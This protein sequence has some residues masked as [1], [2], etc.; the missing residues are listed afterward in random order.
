MYFKLF[1]GHETVRRVETCVSSCFTGWQGYK[2][3]EECSLFFRQMEA[4]TATTAATGATES[5][6]MQSVRRK[7]KARRSKPQLLQDLARRSNMTV[8]RLKD[9][10]AELADVSSF[11]SE[12]SDI[13]PSNTALEL[14]LVDSDGTAA[15]K[16]EFALEEII[17]TSLNE[18][19]KETE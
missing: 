7:A 9:F 16:L 3:S 12:A 11:I 18:G 1:H 10:L 15:D 19:T 17:D 5:K 8:K 13:W 14:P 4:S 2:W 6:K